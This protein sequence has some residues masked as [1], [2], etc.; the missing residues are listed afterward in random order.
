MSCDV[1]SHL[2]FFTLASKT[3]PLLFVL[4]NTIKCAMILSCHNAPVAGLCS[5]GP[6]FGAGPIS[7][8]LYF[9]AGLR[10]G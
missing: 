7:A 8:G 9:G 1:L 3:F 6:H 5:A 4:A 2:S 10:R